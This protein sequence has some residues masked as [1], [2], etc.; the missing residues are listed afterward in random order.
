[1]SRRPR[2]F[3]MD[4]ILLLLFGVTA[5]CLAE[6]FF[7][8]STAH[9]GPLIHVHAACGFLL[10]AVSLIHAFR[11]RK[12]FVGVLKGKI[13]GKARVKCLMYLIATIL[14]TLAC[15]SGGS[16]MDAPGISVFHAITGTAVLMGLAVHVVKH[17]WWMV[18]AWRK[19]APRAQTEDAKRLALQA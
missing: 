13:R 11:H 1:M 9:P 19:P 18:A 5:L 10:F 17:W 4:V 3:R 14:M 6:S 12:W 2:N 7:A 16:A 8:Q 15:F